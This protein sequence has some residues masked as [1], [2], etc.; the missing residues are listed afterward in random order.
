MKRFLILCLFGLLLPEENWAQF[1]VLKGKV[2]TEEGYD[3]HDRAPG[4]PQGEPTY[5]ALPGAYVRWSHDEASTTVSDGFGFFKI[6]KSEVGDTLVVSM[7]G[8]ETVGWVFNGESY[9]DIPLKA[10]VELASAEVVEKKAATQLSL[11]SPLDVQSLNRKELVKAACCN[12]SEAFETNASV[13]ASFTD[14]VTGTR[15]IRMVGLDGKYSQ[16]QVDN[17][18]GPR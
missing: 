16:I 8:F 10:G 1:N 17:L 7:M 15:Q 11:L 13:D 2:L 5:I 18:P 9:V 3:G 12:L 6:G 14:A 4:A